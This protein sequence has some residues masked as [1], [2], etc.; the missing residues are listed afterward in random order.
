MEAMKP[1]TKAAEDLIRDVEARTDLPLACR[2]SLIRWL[3]WWISN[4]PPPKKAA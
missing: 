1:R 4:P 3:R 2:E